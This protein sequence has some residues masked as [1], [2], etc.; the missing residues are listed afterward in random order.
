MAELSEEEMP[1]GTRV[2]TRC[3]L[4][5]NDK[6]EYVQGTLGVVWAVLPDGTVEMLVD[7]DGCLLRAEPADLLAQP[8]LPVNAKVCVTQATVVRPAGLAVGSLRNVT[9]ATVGTV[10]AADRGRATYTVRFPTLG[11]RAEMP[12]AHVVAL[13]GESLPAPLPKSPSLCSVGCSESSDASPPDSPIGNLAKTPSRSSLRCPYA[14]GAYGKHVGFGA[15]VKA[16]AAKG[17]GK[18]ILGCARAWLGV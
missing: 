5:A 9:K 14:P 12:A 6:T 16:P 13:G 15:H 10:T 1:V 18:T 3:W 4:A 7:A 8:V 17:V 2:V 11:I